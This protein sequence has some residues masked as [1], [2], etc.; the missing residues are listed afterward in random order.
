MVGPGGQLEPNFPRLRLRS[1]KLRR[2]SAEDHIIIVLP[3]QNR[4]RSARASQ[5]P[6]PFVSTYLLVRL[7]TQFFQR[8]KHRS[9]NNLEQGG[10][11]VVYLNMLFDYRKKARESYLDRI[12][13]GRK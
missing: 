11:L 7:P 12:S 8:R 9:Q 13:P 10:V 6:G 4:S 2:R 5:D 3:A 1:F